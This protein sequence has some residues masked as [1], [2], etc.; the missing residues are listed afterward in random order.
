M[1]KFIWRYNKEESIAWILKVRVV[2][3]FCIGRTPILL[4]L[5][6]RKL[7]FVVI[8]LSQELDPFDIISSESLETKIER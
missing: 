4:K 8:I 1:E 3:V 2:H 7:M 5:V 6:S